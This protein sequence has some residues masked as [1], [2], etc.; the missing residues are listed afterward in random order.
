MADVIPF[1]VN[2]LSPYFERRKILADLQ[3]R[4][5][6]DADAVRQVAKDGYIAL[7]LFLGDKQF[8]FGD[9]PTSLD[10][11]AFGHLAQVISEKTGLHT[12]VNEFPNLCA[13]YSRIMATYFIPQND[14]DRRSTNPFL[15][16]WGLEVTISST[17][18]SAP[19]KVVEGPDYLSFSSHA[20]IPFFSRPWE[21][22]K[23]KKSPEDPTK[24]SRHDQEEAS[25]PRE[26]GVKE[27]KD[28]FFFDTIFLATSLISFV[29]Y[30]SIRSY[31]LDRKS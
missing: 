5:F 2:I 9:A 16:Y 21:E 7:S 10:A 18:S 12:V 30:L 11:V 27:D 14:S 31:F 23:K 17:D 4:G 3:Y 29:G 24:E 20:D 26:A 15:V 19:P 22:Q 28:E 8:F 13:F 25:S 6:T 1:P